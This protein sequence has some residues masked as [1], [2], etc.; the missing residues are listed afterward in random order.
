MGSFT[1]ALLAH[2]HKGK[3]RQ[4]LIYRCDMKGAK[5]DVKGLKSDV[6]ESV[7]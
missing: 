5:S 3:D 2:W 6:K 4:K 7:G 1:K